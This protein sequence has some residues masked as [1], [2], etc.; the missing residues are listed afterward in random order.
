MSH[1]DSDNREYLRESSMAALASEFHALA[2]GQTQVPRQKVTSRIRDRLVVSGL[3]NYHDHMIE[4]CGPLFSHFLASVPNILEEMCRVGI[5][6]SQ[7]SKKRAL[8][9]GRSCTFFEVD[10]FDGTNGRTLAAISGGHI[11]TVT[12]SPNPANET[13]FHRYADPK[14]SQFVSGS[15]LSVDRNVLSDLGATVFHNGFDYIYET[16]AFQFYGVERDRQ[17]DHVMP[18]LRPDGLFF[19]LEKCLN[20]DIQEYQRRE[21]VK[22]CFH[23]TDY[24]SKEEIAWK[25]TQM[26]TRMKQGEVTL[27]DLIRHIRVRFRYVYVLWNG[28]NFYELVASNSAETMREFLDLLGPLVVE[29]RF[30]MESGLPFSAGESC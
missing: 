19:F 22:D 29:D 1:P 13:A 14:A 28:T 23:K 16:A 2:T 27:T 5:A 26:L 9:T 12:C 10:A 30:C 6:L 17:I 20:D 7:L 24:F 18:L 4:S 15:F 3:A 8:S 21:D 25:K 11:M